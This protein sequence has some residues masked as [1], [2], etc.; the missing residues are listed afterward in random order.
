MKARLDVDGTAKPRTRIIAH[1][2]VGDVVGPWI[3]SRNL[4]YEA[5]DGSRESLSS[6]LP[7][8]G[9][10]FTGNELECEPYACTD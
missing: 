5:E 2:R 6:R 4:E 8:K 9:M 3:S 10:Y 1:P 7:P